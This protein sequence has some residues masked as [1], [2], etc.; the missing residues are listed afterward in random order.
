MELYGATVRA[1]WRSPDVVGGFGREKMVGNK[2]RDNWGSLAGNEA[3]H[4]LL[5]GRVFL[6][7]VLC[8]L[9]F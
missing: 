1:S 8:R 4:A 7:D 5:S 9:I 2:V 6:G 3:K